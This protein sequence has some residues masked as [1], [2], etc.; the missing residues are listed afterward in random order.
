MTRGTP[1]RA[2]R[3]LNLNKTKE[4]TTRK[5]AGDDNDGDTAPKRGAR[6]G[7]ATPTP[8]SDTGGIRSRTRSASKEADGN[9]NKDDDTDIQRGARTTAETSAM[10]PSLP[11]KDDGAATPTSDTGGIGSRT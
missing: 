10:E 2:E 11:A 6:A 3:L 9:K 4:A 8:T 5:R 7:A 1:S